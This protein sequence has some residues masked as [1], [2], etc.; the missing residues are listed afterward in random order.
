MLFVKVIDNPLLVCVNITH[1]SY[2][3]SHQMS[4][5]TYYTVLIIL[6][7][8]FKYFFWLFQSQRTLK[9]SHDLVMAKVDEQTEQLKEERL[10]NLNLESQLQLKVLEQRRIEEV[11]LTF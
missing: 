4:F 3:V 8:G 7:L 6:L 1:A 2:S 11:H 5:M 9:A 10:K